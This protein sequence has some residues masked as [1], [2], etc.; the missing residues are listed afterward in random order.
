MGFLEQLLQQQTAAAQRQAKALELLATKREKRSVYSISPKTRLPELH[1]GDTQVKEFFTEFRR[2]CNLA[3]DG[4]G[5][6]DPEMFLYL[7][8]SLAGSRL[9]NYDN[10]IKLTRA[11]GEYDERPEQVFDQIE[12]KLLEAQESV[13]EKTDQALG[14]VARTRTGQSF[15]RSLPAKMGTPRRGLGL[16]RPLPKR[17]KNYS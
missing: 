12:T 10:I 15:A 14:R 7:K 6:S 17:Q 13:G 11:S 9:E 4:E 8:D 3:N 1:D 16:C 2:H 5:M